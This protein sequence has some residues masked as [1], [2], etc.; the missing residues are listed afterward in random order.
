MDEIGQGNKNSLGVTTSEGFWRAVFHGVN[1]N[2][3][4]PT[5]IKTGLDAPVYD[6]TPKGTLKPNRP[7]M[8]ADK[9]GE[10]NKSHYVSERDGFTDDAPLL[11]GKNGYTTISVNLEEYLNRANKNTR[12]G[13]VVSPF[14][15]VFGVRDGFSWQ[16]FLQRNVSITYYYGTFKKKFGV[17][18]G[19]LVQT[20]APMRT[21][22]CVGLQ[23]FYPGKEA[24]QMRDFESVQLV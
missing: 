5:A 13:I 9:W 6:M 15:C 8:N 7:G 20:G 18:Y 2:T 16:F 10:V 22:Y 3:A 4:N 21:A 12:T 11:L 19:D 14:G 1:L 24:I 23:Q 17:S